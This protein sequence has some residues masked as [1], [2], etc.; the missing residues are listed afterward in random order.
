MAIETS[1]LS[2]FERLSAF[3]IVRLRLAN[4]P[5][6][7]RW[8][9]MHLYSGS[10]RRLRAELLEMRDVDQQM[11]MLGMQ[12]LRLMDVDVDVRNTAR[13]KEIIAAYGWTGKSLVGAEGADAAWLLVQHADHDRAFQKQCLQLLDQAVQ[14]GEADPRHL[15]YL[16]DRVR[17]AEG[18][19][20]VYGT[21]FRSFT[22]PFPI[23]AAEQVDERRAQ[24]GLEP[25]AEYAERMRQLSN[26]LDEHK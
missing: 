5:P 11:R 9:T 20:Q 1:P 2:P 12:Y 26:R 16:T 14:N 8:L 7:Q 3:L 15:A 19:F 24:V 18:E 21:Q 13:M 22:E 4:V 10:N 23:E 6:F 25:L 17:V